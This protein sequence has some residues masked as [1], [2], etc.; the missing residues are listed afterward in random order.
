MITAIA[1]SAFRRRSKWVTTACVALGVWITTLLALNLAFGFSTQGPVF[2]VREL[3]VLAAGVVM[4]RIAQADEYKRAVA[5]GLRVALVLTCAF[6]IWQEY[7]GLRPLLELGYTDGFFYATADG[8]YRPFG[9]FY[10]P[11]VYG[12]FVAMLGIAVIATTQR[13]IWRLV[14]IALT[15]YVVLI[16]ETRSAIL[17]LLLAAAVIYIRRFGVVPAHH[18]IWYVQGVL[19]LLIVYLMG[20]VPTSVTT[21]WDRL[22]GATEAGDT[23]RGTRWELWSA[24]TAAINDQHLWLIGFQDAAF[25]PIVT[26]YTGSSIASLGHAHSNYFQELFRYGYPGLLLFLV[27]LGTFVYTITRSRPFVPSGM[28]AAGLGGLIVFAVDS[29]FNNSLSSFNVFVTLFLI[30]GLGCSSQA[31]Q[32]KQGVTRYAQT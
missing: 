13:L 8:N 5:I 27:L 4:F 3:L 21:V 1:T 7:I 16:T 25:A 9:T 6:G 23:S 22:M 20:W 18:I 30:V 15:T 2:L 31:Y 11:T 19:L 24:V 32:R 14:W 29:F 26:P 17:G 10:S 28:S 12:A